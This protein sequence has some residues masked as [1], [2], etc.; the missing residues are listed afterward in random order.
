M[1]WGVVVNGQNETMLIKVDLE[2][3]LGGHWLS[4]SSHEVWS[5]M[6]SWWRQPPRASHLQ[7]YQLVKTCCPAPWPLP[8]SQR[9]S[10]LS[11]GLGENSYAFRERVRLTAVHKQLSNKPELVRWQKKKRMVRQPRHWRTGGPPVLKYETAK[12]WV[13]F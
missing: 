7:L 9:T 5:L 4:R 11:S 8:F 1:A 10:P 3:T 12:F 6:P 2:K 13:E